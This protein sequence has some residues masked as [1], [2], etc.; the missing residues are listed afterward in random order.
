MP[1]SRPSRFRHVCP[2]L[3]ETKDGLRCSANTVDV[4]PFWGRVLAYYGS[5]AL[6]IY[7][8]GVI[9]VFIFLRTVGYP[10]N[11][12]HVALPPLW[13]RV[14]E[15][16]GWFFL[17]RS[18]RAFAAGR[19]AEGLLYLANSYEFD[20]RNYTTGLSL[21]KS[22]QI[23]QPAQSD[24]VFKQLLLEHPD[25]R[26]LT[27]QEWF[28]AMLSRGSFVA[29]AKLAREELL[30]DPAHA[31]VWVRALLFATSQRQ[32]NEELRGLA[33][34]NSAEARIWRQLFETE[35][36][37]R[38]NQKAEARAALARSWPEPLNSQ[39]RFLLFYRV[40]A[41][42]ELSAAH[43]AIDLL[44]KYPRALDAEAEVTLKLEAFSSIG[45]THL[46]KVQLDELLAP[47]F[48]LANLAI[49]KI[50]CAHLIRNPD[51]AIFDRLSK[52]VEREQLPLSTETAGAWFSLLCTAG[53][54]GDKV[55]LH[56]ITARLKQASNSPFKALDVAEAFFRGET[57]DRRITMILP[58]LPVPLEV[59]YALL[60]RYGA[61]STAPIMLP[62]R[63]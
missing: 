56:E 9:G 59:S 43:A 35:L 33:A 26:H 28:R 16:R 45:A 61:A 42:T 51:T 60:E 49:I 47:R 34:N 31:A 55:R 11:I 29:I 19:T 15:T 3:V 24:R 23:G 27:A 4:R 40:N 50:L 54:V 57:N 14:T 41:L 48:T 44:G 21:A 6:A 62:K 53:A 30:T 7:G 36:M 25:K 20:P 37:I 39:S 52:K 8:V 10:V 2:L 18:N 5:T 17:E 32:S 63:P 1:W 13:H 22:F 58:I 38:T 12:F 46:L